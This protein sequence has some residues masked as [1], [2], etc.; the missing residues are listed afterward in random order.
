MKQELASELGIDGFEDLGEELA[1]SLL[2]VAGRYVRR[3]DRI[4]KGWGITDDQYNVLRILQASYPEGEPRFA[5][6]ER[7]INRAPDVTRLLD[8]LESKGL[9]ERNRSGTDKRRSISTIT[10]EG[11]ALL[12]AMAD[13]VRGMNQE[14]TEKLTG[15]ERRLLLDFLRRSLPME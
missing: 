8:R 9:V 15:H 11:T 2:L 4:C 3:L 5:I 13:D 12:D 6:A 10:P 7:L 1:V 14:L